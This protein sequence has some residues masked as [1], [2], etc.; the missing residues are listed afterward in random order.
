MRRLHY[1]IHT[2]RAYTDWIK[3]FVKFHYRQAREELLVEPEKKVEDYLTHLA[4]RANVA[5]ATQN[6]AF[7]AL[8]FLYKRVAVCASTQIPERGAG[9]GLAVR[10]SQPESSERPAQRGGASP[11]CR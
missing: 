8:V 3:R 7:N 4:V 11:P 2:E 1:S 10:F 9:V 6:Q 5:A